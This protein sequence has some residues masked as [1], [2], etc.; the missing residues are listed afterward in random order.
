MSDLHSH[1]S[2][3]I[4]VVDDIPHNLRLLSRMLD[5]QGYNVRC[6]T[7]P[8][9]ALQA[10]KTKPPDLLLLDVKMPQ[11]S[12]YDLCQLLKQDEQ[13]Q[14]IPVIFISALDELA[15]KLRGFEVGGVD[16][17]T[18]P[19]HEAEILMRVKMQITLQQQRKQLLD[20][21][22]KLTQ[23]IQKR[24][25]TEVSLQASEE[26]YRN[27][28]EQTSDWIWE[29]DANWQLT[30]TNAQIT[31]ILGYPLER[32]IGLSFHDL[33]AEDSYERFVDA[34]K[35]LSGDRASTQLEVGVRH[36]S[37][38]I[39]EFET[40][41]L[42][43]INPQ[44]VLQGYR[45][46]AR[47]ISRRKQVEHEIRQALSRQKEINEFKSRFVSVI[48][49]EF[50][51]PLT[52]IQSSADILQNIPCTE[53]DREELLM[54]IQAAVNHMTL[55]VDDVVV[56]GQAEAGKL[57]SVP[58]QLNLEQFLR[59]LLR[60][61]E[62]LTQPNHRI[63][64][65][66]ESSSIELSVDQKLLRQTITNLVSNAIKYSPGGGAI[67]I[68]LRRQNHDAIIEVSDSGI[69][70]PPEDQENLFECFHRAQNVGTIPGTGIGL[71]ITRECVRLHQGDIDVRSQVG[72][73]TTFTIRF[74]MEPD[75]IPDDF[76]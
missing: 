34:L 9:M 67:A 24:Q 52:V 4:L 57:K 11:M 5:M 48:S 6:T 13:T 44:G 7:S 36:V 65:F 38:D 3:D 49:H 29:C 56:V 61:F 43:R 62:V 20:Q 66:S 27:L 35:H 46:I 54:R 69:G 33:M 31:S 39:V 18:K 2:A 76:V 72:Q 32:A 59:D 30:Y 22:Q 21:N 28:V 60:E 74:P 37:G 23:E 41:G 73:G 68:H 1:L 71:F 15:D 70:I 17:V 64:F 8:R 19:F 16:Y 45:G 25:Q 42:V 75:D 14:A 55:L 63:D 12:G 10:A 47:D 50:R 26:Q 53:S 51:T 40:S 58:T